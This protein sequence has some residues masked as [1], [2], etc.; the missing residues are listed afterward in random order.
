MVDHT[1]DPRPDAP[2]PHH[3][4][5]PLLTL[6]TERSLDEDYAHVAAR[7]AA[8]GQVRTPRWKV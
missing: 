3:V 1:D 5:T 8:N 7:R 2:L 6:I 4:T